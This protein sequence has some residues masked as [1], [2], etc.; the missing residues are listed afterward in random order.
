MTNIDGGGFLIRA[1]PAANPHPTRLGNHILFA[2]VVSAKAQLRL[3]APYTSARSKDK[4]KRCARLN[5]ATR[6]N[7]GTK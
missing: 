6:R 3:V 1:Y 5:A 7:F 4:Q 2:F